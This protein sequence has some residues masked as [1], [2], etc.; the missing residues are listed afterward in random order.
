[1][2]RKA[3]QDNS[4]HDIK[5]EEEEDES[6][7]EDPLYTT[8][9][10]TVNENRALLRILKNDKTSG[11]DWITL[12]FYKYG[13]EELIQTLTRIIQIWRRKIISQEWKEAVIVLLYKKGDIFNCANYTRMSLLNTTYNIVSKWVINR[14]ILYAEKIVGD[15]QGGFTKERS[16][17]DQVFIIQELASKYW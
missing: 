16:T 13:G 14:L 8:L 17:M 10:P 12:E 3:K 15:Y 4:Q 9:E 11:E 6:E 2:L 7:N 1:M 5:G